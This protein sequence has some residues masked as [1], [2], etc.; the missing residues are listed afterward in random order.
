M[1]KTNLVKTFALTVS[2]LLQLSTPCFQSHGAAG[3]V[4]LSFDPGS[5]INGTVTALALQPDGKMIIGGQFTTVKGL[6]RNSVARLNADGSGDSSFNFAPLYSYQSYDTVRCVALQP[7]GKV[8]VGHYY[9]IERFN[10]DGSLDTNFFASIDSLY[11]ENFGAA[12]INAVVVQTDGKVIIGGNF[13]VAN[14]TNVNYAIA[15]LNSNGS[16]D[17]SFDGGT[18]VGYSSVS[19]VALQA[20]GKVLVGHDYGFVRLSANGSLDTSFDAG[21]GTFNGVVNS[22]VL[23]PDNKMLIAG[24]FSIVNGTNRN[25]IARLNA[26]GTLDGTFSS[27]TG[28]NWCN[29]RSV[30]VEPDG[31]IVIGGYFSTNNGT[32][33]NQVARFT[34]N[35]GLDGSFD[36]GTGANNWIHCL[37]LQSDGRVLF[38]GVFNIVNGTNRIGMARL[39]ANGSLDNTFDPGSGLGSPVST[40]VL[41]SDGKLL[42]GD[43]LTFING[44]NRYASARLNPDGSRDVGFIPN[45]FN[46]QTGVVGFDY[47]FAERAAVQSDGKVL[48]G[49]WTATVLNIDEFNNYYWLFGY[50]VSR[51]NADGSHDSSFSPV[52]GDSYGAWGW[53]DPWS[54]RD[55]WSPT[56]R[57]LAA[58]PD[59]KVLVGSY[60]IFR[61]NSN[62]SSDASFTNSGI[63][64]VNA[65][66]LQPDGRL[67]VGADNGVARLYSNGSRDPCFNPTIANVYSLALQPDG[68]VLV[69]GLFFSVNGVTRNGIARLN[70][71]GS[72]DTTFDSGTGAS[73]KV[74]AITLQ[75]DGN[76]LIGGDFLTVNN[77]TRPYVARLFGG[78]S[79]PRL[80]LFSTNN[81]VVV[82]WPSPSDGFTLQQTT[83]LTAPNWVTVA[84]A[85]TT[86]GLEKQVAVSPPTGRRFF[87][88]IS[89][90][91]NPPQLPAPPP[92]APGLTAVAGDASVSLSW[93]A[94]AGATGHHVQ[95]ATNNNGSFTTIASPATANHTDTTVV[96][97]TTYYYRVSVTYPCG[98]STSSAPVSA[99]PHVTPTVH[100]QSITMSWVPQGARYY[101][102]AVVKV[103]DNMGNPF[104]GATVTGN[105]TGSIDNPGRT[106]VTAPNGEA[107]LT[108]SSTIKNGTVT[109]TVAG[110]AA[111]IGY[112]PAANLV[113]SATIIR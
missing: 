23:Q 21:S 18:V 72:L 71:N 75:P 39:N 104:N 42:I 73:A 95:R 49:G 61:L 66:V 90:A 45:Y 2:L 27:N 62:G 65:I 98:E 30:V 56:V 51:F 32:N 80:R 102:R 22:I 28:S 106:G 68:K 69:G 110:I 6:T 5:G 83:N 36:P 3:D 109:F 105:F 33:R 91:A 13:Y 43:G 41:Q 25:G 38:G 93:T 44:T 52:T 113:S 76:V 35:G 74:R 70:D 78:V 26:N 81:V 24:G 12:I 92:P 9:G 19:A 112:N 1:K 60:R 88:L 103:I 57:A 55:P 89:N 50:F 108:S 16:V 11:D 34:V 87:R 14:A 64:N 15:R 94:L 53:S 86:V 37:A 17:S 77:V 101:T 79:G 59:G 47:V 67:L 31:R 84:T 40:L 100:I 85:P 58:Q 54:A 82:A 99:M 10:S 107:I 97:G 4:D 111:V 8:L 46:P 29:V 96:N 20:D 48:I 63:Y 7:D